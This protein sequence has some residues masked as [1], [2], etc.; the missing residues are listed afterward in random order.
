MKICFLGDI[1][2]G[3]R[4]DSLFF[5]ENQIKSLN[6]VVE[7]CEENNIDTIIQLGDIFDR[8]KYINFNTLNIAKKSFFDVLLKKNIRMIVVIGNHDTFHKNTSVINSPTLLLSEYENIT[9]IEK[10]REIDFDG[11]QIGMAAWINSE[12]YEEITTSIRS[13]KAELLC[14]HFELNS[15]YNNSVEFDGDEQSLFG[16]FSQVFSGH[17]HIWSSCSNFCYVG[18]VTQLT[19]NDYGHLKSFMIFDVETRNTEKI[20]IEEYLFEMID[21]SDDIDLVRFDYSI[22]QDKI[23]R[24]RV[25]SFEQISRNKFDIFIERLVSITH[26]TEVIESSI[27]FW[28]ANLESDS[29]NSSDDTLSLLKNHVDLIVQD[30]SFD[31]AKI[32]SEIDELYQEALS[33]GAEE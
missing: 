6:R 28:K 12:N 32:I 20:I 11:C 8:R 25:P 1:H 19:W 14:G 31:R 5:L 27:D 13:S 15:I 9:I 23:V 26:T 16:K 18:C 2:F 29:E 22:F 3:A 21:Y 33:K 30:R 24:V 7:Y 4:S 10:Y 17:Y